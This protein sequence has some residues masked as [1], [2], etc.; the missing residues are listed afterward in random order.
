MPPLAQRR[1]FQWCA[2]AVL[3]VLLAFPL[4]PP[5]TRFPR[6]LLA[7]DAY[8]YVKIAWNLGR[9]GMSS[10]DGIHTTDGY[11]LLWGWVLGL[12]SALTGWFTAEPRF[13]L[14]AMLWLYFMVCWAIGIWFGRNWVETLLLFAMGIVFKVMMETTLLALLLLALCEREYLAPAPAPR[15]RWSPLLLVLLP[16]IRID[17][18]LIGGVLVLSP[19]LGSPEPGRRPVDRVLAGA[20]WL[21]L[22]ALLQA[23]AHFLLFRRWTSVSMELKGFDEASV[24]DRLRHN[25]T[26][27]HGANGVPVILF[28]LLWGLAILAV[29]PRPKP[30]RARHLAVLA[31]PAVFV[32]FHLAANNTINYWYF[33]PAAYLHAWYFLRFGPEASTRLG[34]AGRAAIAAVPL[35]F[36]AKWAIDG[37]IR[38]REIRW[39]RQ[40]VGEV[41]RRVPPDEPIFQMDASGW[42]GWFSVRQVVNGDGLVNDHDY[43]RRLSERRLAGYLKEQGIRYIVQNLY[44]E[45]GMLIGDC[46]GLTVSMDS[47]ETL[48][49]PPPGF[50][51][52][53]AFGLYRLKDRD[54]TGALISPPP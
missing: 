20:G 39:A 7:D 12:T 44:P 28:V 2:A 41:R 18:I 27:F 31:A 29:L 37:R 47:V 21:V 50:P 25:V 16:L 1:A 43:A 32:L 9:H 36:I 35:L 46:G 6:G 45:N 34:W 22:G 15:W 54:A 24:L 19:F 48:V 8:F 14:G 26:G 11:H 13:H 40:F 52:L 4:Q 49:P 23:G 3:S 38:D 53:S 5:L 30:E 42:V 17:A 51:D 33:V 10:F